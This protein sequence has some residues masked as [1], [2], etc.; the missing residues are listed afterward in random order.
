MPLN[1][2][3]KGSFKNLSC[4][5][6]QG[7]LSGTQC[8]N[9]ALEF[10]QTHGILDLRWPQQPMSRDTDSAVEKILANYD[11][12]TFRELVLMRFE[13][14]TEGTAVPQSLVEFYQNYHRTLAE[15]G[16]QMIGMFQSRT[17]ENFTLPGKALALDIG[18]GVG[19]SSLALAKEFDQVIGIDPSLP[20]LLLAQKYFAENEIS[21]VTLVQAYAQHLPVKSNVVDFGVAQN[22]LEHLFHVEAAFHEIVRVLTEGGCFCGDSRNRYDLF[23]PEPHAQIRWVGFLPRKWQPWYVNKRR[24][25]P[26]DDTHLLSKGEL[27]KFGS[28]AFGHSVKVTYPLSIAYGRSPKWD[29]WIYRLEKIPLLNNLF[30]Q[31]YPSHLFIGKSS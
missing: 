23:L 20:S 19:A 1:E 17:E 7:D 30:L 12:S 15:R 5:V 29:K 22:V 25:I 18:C 21:N 4:P 13:I 24:Q 2:E 31:I 27:T 11:K 9:C 14:A 3:P 8:T 16:Q 26:Y 10:S 28:K 6:C